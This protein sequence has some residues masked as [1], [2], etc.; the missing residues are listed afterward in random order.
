MTVNRVRLLP[1]R[2]LV[3][4]RIVITYGEEG[5]ATSVGIGNQSLRASQAIG[6]ARL[7]VNGSAYARKTVKVGNGYDRPNV[8]A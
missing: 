1:H 4:G 5:L 2:V 8:A 3:R 6:Q 7:V